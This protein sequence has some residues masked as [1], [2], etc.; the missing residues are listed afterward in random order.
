[1]YKNFTLIDD[2]TRHDHYHLTSAD[3]C[4]YYGEYTARRGFSHSGTNQLIWDL[5]VAIDKNNQ[6]QYKRRGIASM[7]SVLIKTIPNPENIV[8]V[9]VPPSKAKTDPLYDDR[10]VEILRQYQAAV[11]IVDYRELLVQKT[12]TRASHESDDRLSPDELAALYSIDESLV[13]D[14]RSSIVIFDDMLTTGSHFKAM[15]SVLSQRFPQIRIGGLFVARRVFWAE[16][17]EVVFGGF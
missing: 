7:A 2:N 6:L 13:H 17:P 8:F 9:P 5:K 3:Y 16:D 12:T 15:Q 4:A 14:M 1:M 11:P 10:M